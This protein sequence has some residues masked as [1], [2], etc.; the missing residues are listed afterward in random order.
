[1]EPPFPPLAAEADQRAEIVFFEAL[2]KSPDERVDFLNSECGTD[3]RLRVEVDGLLRD[4][5]KAGSFLSSEGL[6]PAEL[7][8]ELVRGQTEE[9]GAMIGPYKQA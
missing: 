4:H 5:E 8:A 7:E 2:K 9:A 3:T 6:V 1:M